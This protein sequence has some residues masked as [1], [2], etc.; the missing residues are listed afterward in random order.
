MQ[1]SQCPANAITVE[2][3]SKCF[4]TRAPF[5][6][7][8]PITALLEGFTRINQ[9]GSEINGWDHFLATEQC[10]VPLFKA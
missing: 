6:P 4:F 5:H 2:S 8:I 1:Q 3:Y 7:L 9:D 10:A